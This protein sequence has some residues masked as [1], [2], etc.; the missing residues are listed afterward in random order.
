MNAHKSVRIVSMHLQIAYQEISVQ[1]WSKIVELCMGKINWK[2]HFKYH[3]V[4]Y[5]ENSALLTEKSA[6]LALLVIKEYF[7]VYWCTTLWGK[8]SLFLQ[9][10]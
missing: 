5:R 10:L 7:I 8:A 1:L 9:Q 2:V 6:L 4:Y 3:E